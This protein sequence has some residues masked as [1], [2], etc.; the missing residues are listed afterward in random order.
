[1]L[2]IVGGDGQEGVVG[3]E[4]ASPL[5]VRV[6]DANG[7]PV[8]GQLVNFR[9]TAGGGSVFAGSGITNALGVVQDRWTLGTSTA[10]SQRVEARA[11]DP[12]TGARIVFATFRATARPGP[13]Q[14]LT[15]TAGDAQQ[16]TLGSALA[17]SLAVRVA[18]AFGNPVPSVTVAWAPPLQNGAVNPVASQTNAQGI[19]K[20]AWTL[21]T[22]LDIPHVVTALVPSVPPATFSATAALPSDARVEK[23]GGDSQT[24]T[25]A[26]ALTDSL[27]A[28]LVLANGAPVGGAL[29][30]WRV[31]AGGGSL[32][33]DTTRTNA[34]GRA[35][36]RWTLGQSGG[37]NRVR[38][39]I[40]P[41][42]EV[43]FAANAMA[44]TGATIA[45]VSG[46]AQGGQVAT[47]LTYPMIVRVTDA[48]GQPVVGIDVTWT[49]IEGFETPP[50][51]A[52]VATDADGL[53]RRDFCLGSRA[54]TKR[55]TAA[56]PGT[57]T[58]TFTHTAT[59]GRIELVG[60]I[61][62]PA[63]APAGTTV[64][65]FHFRVMDLYQNPI[66]NYRL[67]WTMLP[68]P[69]QAAGQCGSITSEPTDAEGLARSFWT[70]CNV[71][72][73]Q[74]GYHFVGGVKH[75]FII[76]ATAP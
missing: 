38:V 40:A 23:I 50:P 53:S 10:D 56:A 37:A 15:R 24:G 69:G 70:L 9:V 7:L 73:L 66:P 27:R 71:A 25:L 59:P 30:R 60:V 39:G 57:N 76:Q 11:V 8:I 42:S 5:V 55:V 31:T 74:S 20:T 29:L 6:E 41:L 75:Q 18:D 1:V 3:T 35:A 43:E 17:E 52:T 21:G 45:I 64:G 54:G 22:R 58:V 19:A 68:A 16:A 61:G 67:T 12:N 26:G 2:D 32:S 4:L 28:R 34:D 33:A 72:G 14:S 49:V 62:L 51:P 36:V 65:P 44:P 48:G 63:S 47:C 46:D 13:A